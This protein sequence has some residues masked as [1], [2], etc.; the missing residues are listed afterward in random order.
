MYVSIYYL[1]L[2]SVYFGFTNWQLVNDPACLYMHCLKNIH[3][4]F[5]HNLVE[6]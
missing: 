6:S 5:V 2:V 4:V 3:S 1:C